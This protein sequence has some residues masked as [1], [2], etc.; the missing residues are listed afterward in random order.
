LTSRPGVA[1]VL[2]GYGLPPGWRA[3]AGD[4]SPCGPEFDSEREAEA[5]GEQN[6]VGWP[7]ERSPDSSVGGGEG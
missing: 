5:W 2:R 4:G 7:V 3:V 1:E 6:L